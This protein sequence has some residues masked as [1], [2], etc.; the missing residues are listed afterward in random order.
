LAGVLMPVAIWLPQQS[1]VCIAM[2]QSLA[3]LQ[4]LS[5][6]GNGI[7]FRQ[8]VST[9]ELPPAESTALASATPVLASAIPVPVSATPVLASAAT[10]HDAPR[11]GSVV[12]TGVH[13]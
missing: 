12:Q 7:W 8:Q 5:S 3:T 13:T 1:V 2:K 11:H 6:G 10:T 4:L 9:T